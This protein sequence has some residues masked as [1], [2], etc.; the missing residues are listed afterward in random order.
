MKGKNPAPS[1]SEFSKS[2]V[3]SPFGDLRLTEITRLS[4][5]WAVHFKE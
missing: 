2:I 5:R 1:Q 4:L 3:A